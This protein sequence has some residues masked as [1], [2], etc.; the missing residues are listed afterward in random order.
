MTFSSLEKLLL[1]LEDSWLKRSVPLSNPRTYPQVVLNV[2][3]EVPLFNL[4]YFALANCNEAIAL[5]N[6][7]LPVVVLVGINYT[8]GIQPIPNGS[9]RPQVIDCP[10]NLTTAITKI[11]AAATHASGNLNAWRLSSLAPQSGPCP[12]LAA[13]FHVV[14]T[15]LSPY[16]TQKSWQSQMCSGSLALGS[17]LLANPPYTPCRHPGWPFDHLHDLKN[18]LPGDDT[19]W[20]GHGLEAVGPYWHQLVKVMGLKN[21]LLVGNL[22]SGPPFRLRVNGAGYVKFY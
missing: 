7:P 14:M 2:R 6:D 4:Q 10:A 19:I 20:I 22:F 1:P 17:F 18:I 16:I 8:Q 13:G 5:S 9:K 12:T 21:W 11:K 3:P 15:N